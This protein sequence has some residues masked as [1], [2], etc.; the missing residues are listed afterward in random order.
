M[1][2]VGATEAAFLL[3]GFDIHHHSTPGKNLPVHLEDQNRVIVPEATEAQAASNPKKPKNSIKGV[4][5]IQPKESSLS[6]KACWVPGKVH[7]VQK[8]NCEQIA[9]VLWKWFVGFT[10]SHLLRA[11]VLLGDSSTKSSLLRLISAIQLSNKNLA[12]QTNVQSKFSN[13][14]VVNLNELQNS[15]GVPNPAK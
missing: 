9:N 14:F 3:F 5:Y 11:K 10:V 1:R 12:N 2:S 13:W 6:K 15:A 8:T 7:I 4:P